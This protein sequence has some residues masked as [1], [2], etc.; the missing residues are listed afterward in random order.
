MSIKQEM[1]KGLFWSGIEKYSG[2]IISLIVSAILARL[3]SPEEFG[4]LSAATVIINFLTIFTSMGIF[5]AIIQ[6]KNLTEK[7]LDS[8]FTLSI[9]S[10]FLLASIFFCFSWVIADFYQNIILKTICQLLSINLFF[11]TINLV[12]SALMAKNKRFKNIAQRTLSL[13]IISGSISIIA[14]YQGLGVYALLISP[15]FT[16]IGM[17]CFNLY[18]YPRHIDWTLNIQPIKKIYSYSIYQFLFEFINYFSRNLD[19]LIIG[20]YIN[21]TELGYYDKSYRLMMLP[22]QNITSVITPVMQPVL[23]SLQEDKQHMAQTYNKIIRL[24]ATISF[25]FTVFIYF[26]SYELIN[27]IYGSN[28]NQAIPTFQILSLS[29]PLQM[30]LSTTGS[31]YQASNATKWLFLVGTKNTIITITGFMIATIL[32][33]TI[34]AIGWSWVI[35]QILCFII[36]FTTLYNKVFQASFTQMLQQLKYPLLNGILLT[37]ILYLVSYYLHFSNIFF[38]VTLKLAIVLFTTVI[39]LFSTKQY[40]IHNLIYQIKN[41]F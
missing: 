21:M 22:L 8:I 40:D 27:I 24:I 32:F 7:D 26:T 28:W 1:L 3:I 35:T 33:G 6:N 15:I 37:L 34:E 31:M 14:A 41:R 39:I 9:L 10:G 38:S 20:K 13:Q 4:I 2:I 12:P 30:I 23:S 16:A 36:S 17:F 19:K 11:A 5:P 29:L 18:Y 25:P